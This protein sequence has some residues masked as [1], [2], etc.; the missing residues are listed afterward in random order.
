MTQDP[1]DTYRRMLLIRECE[2]QINDAFAKNQFPGYVHSYLGQ[3]ACAVG[4]CEG[5]T[6][7][8][9]IVSNHRGRGHYLAKG[10]AVKPMM[11]EMFGKA[12]GV[13]GGR[14]GEMH[15]ADPAIGVLGGN[16]I[17]GGGL[18]I[19]AGAALSAQMD[20]N[21][22][23]AV[24]FFGEGASNNGSFGETMNVAAA[25]RLPLILVC[26]N[27]LYAEMTPFSET[28]AQPDLALRA[29]GYGLVGEIV[30][31]N[32][33]VAVREAAGR[34]IARARAGEG[35]TLLELKTYR[36]GGHFEG[37]PR[38]YRT[39]EEEE[40]WKARCPVARFR[41]FLTEKRSIGEERLVAIET[42]VREEIAAAISFAL[43][44]PL[45]APETALSKVYAA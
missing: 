7:T 40:E 25:W 37:D 14:G 20:G 2:A 22:A 3:E 32:D 36:W 15:A 13:C 9:F 30:D 6:D 11:A 12:S 10:M 38:K 33:V 35:P 44:S 18:P 27:N 39:R 23:V 26:E 43:E 17:V 19:A 21:G 5:L 28:V 24:A 41:R 1:L 42:E 31:G 29:A 34:A 4:V 45:P 16:G 8:D